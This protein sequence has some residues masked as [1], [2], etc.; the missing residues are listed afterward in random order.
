MSFQTYTRRSFSYENG[1]APYV[2]YC[3]L[4]SL[5]KYMGPFPHINKYAPYIA[6]YS[7][8]ALCNVGQDWGT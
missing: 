5:L 4:P 6:V 7:P 1:I 2:L 3:D 8:A